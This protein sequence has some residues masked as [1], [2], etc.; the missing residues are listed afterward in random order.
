VSYLSLGV[1]ILG[2][3]LRYILCSGSVRFVFILFAIRVGHLFFRVRLRRL[4][5]LGVA[6]SSGCRRCRRC[7]RWCRRLNCVVEAL[8]NG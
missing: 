1:P 7:R 4:V 3:R 2:W 8:L 6:F 5:Q